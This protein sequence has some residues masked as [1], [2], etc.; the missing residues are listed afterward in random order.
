VTPTG[1]GEVWRVLKYEKA[2]V[3]VTKESTNGST[4]RHETGIVA[5]SL[6]A[7]GIVYGDLGTSPLYSI[8]EA[9]QNRHHRL[10]VDQ[11]NVLGAMSI[12]VW[13][14]FIII[15]VK[16]VLLVMR[17]DNHGEGGILALTAIATAETE[18]A[19]AKQGRRAMRTIGP[20]TVLGLFGTALLFG[21]GMITPAIS[22]MSAVEGAELVQP[23]FERF[24]VPVSVVILIGLFSI[25]R[26]GTGRVGRVFG[27]VMLAWFAMMAV[28]GLMSLWRTPEVLQA[29]NPINA[30]RYF[31]TNTTKGFLS[32]GSLFLV[33]TGGE[34]LYADMGHFGRR[35]ITLGWT[36]VVLPALLLTYLG[37]GGLL[38]REPDAIENPFFRLPPEAIRLPVVILATVATIIA[39]QA[40]ISGVFSLTYQAIQL[41]YAPRSKVIYT[42]ATA[43]GQVYIPVVNWAL[44]I[45][46]VGLVLAFRSSAAL[47]AAFGLSVTGTMFFTTILFAV[48]AKRTWGWHPV[49][50]WALAGGILTIEGAFLLANIFKIPEGGWFPLLV[51][52]IVFT[53]FTTWKTGRALVNARTRAHNITVAQLAATLAKSED[54]A[55][56][57]VPGTA[58]Y[59]SAQAGFVPTSLLVNMRS[60]RALHENVYIVTVMTA[61]T[62]TV[63][64]AKRVEQ[65]EHP[66]NLH[67]V[68]LHYGFME[69]APVAEDLHTHL[70]VEPTA[71]YYFLGRE[72]VHATG[73]V[74]M[75][76]WREALFALMN[77]NTVDISAF[78]SLPHD[79]VVEVGSWVDI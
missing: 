37:I 49:I 77:R 21:D 50:V 46:C 34:A 6:G 60:Q 25:Q 26:F 29:V 16:Y 17:A 55:S 35:P 56:T 13:T 33:V 68:V 64:S 71:T 5:L 47:A 28:F 27:P 72:N 61:D 58:V 2:P 45:A 78:F 23:S 52:F 63:L 10:P 30:V 69:P 19:P 36:T 3:T 73:R 14:L 32:M 44:M 65:T 31:R 24:V 40:L 51:G 1:N 62:P 48:H 39:S 22:V 53:L 4:S 79:R 38:L 42:S 43:R 59:L 15:T 12:I 75:A 76:R 18:A 74:G 66:C 20:L 7:L 11:L 9:F 41:G 8:R 70:Y 67:D 54:R 57:R